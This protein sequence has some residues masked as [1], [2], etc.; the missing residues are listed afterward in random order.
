MYRLNTPAPDIPNTDP[1]L[2]E[3]AVKLIKATLAG[4][5]FMFEGCAQTGGNL[6]TNII[7]LSK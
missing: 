7:G 1:Q 2:C 3:N 5:P 6:V 4:P